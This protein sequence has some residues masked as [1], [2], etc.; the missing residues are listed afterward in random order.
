MPGRNNFMSNVLEEKF[1]GKK[2]NGRPRL[3]IMFVGCGSYQETKR[4]AGN[5]EDWLQL[6]EDYMRGR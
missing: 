4:I 6:L 2:I 3:K 1:T 5:K